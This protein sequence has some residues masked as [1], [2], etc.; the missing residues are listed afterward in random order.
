MLA[1]RAVR[2]EQV[3]QQS[4]PVDGFIGDVERSRPSHHDQDDPEPGCGQCE[5]KEASELLPRK[6][7]ISSTS[8]H[9]GIPY[10]ML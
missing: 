5:G 4:V 2:C 3:L 7:L 10:R 6:K 9:A 8:T 1:N